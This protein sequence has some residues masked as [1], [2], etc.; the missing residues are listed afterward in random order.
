MLLL[1]Y[2][3][4]RSALL[5][6]TVCS[7]FFWLLAVFL[8]SLVWIAIPPLRTVHPFHQVVSVLIQ[9]AVRFALVYTYVRCVGCAAPRCRRARL[10]PPP[11]RHPHAAARR[12]RMR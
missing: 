5:I 9:E 4:R 11:L 3:S 7:A 1:G 8:S 6:L 12:Q 10:P 2:A